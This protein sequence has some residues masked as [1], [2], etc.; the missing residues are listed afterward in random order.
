MLKDK[1]F[2][3]AKSWTKE[4]DQVL[5]DY[6]LVMTKDELAKILDRSFS[7][8]DNRIRKLKQKGILYNN[9]QYLKMLTVREP[10][11]S[12]ISENKINIYITKMKLPYCGAIYIH[13]SNSKLSKKNCRNIKIYLKKR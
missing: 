12:L 2:K 9:S 4:E 11:A 1:F 3:L 10:Y 8:I 6:Y 13:A 7:S 5:I